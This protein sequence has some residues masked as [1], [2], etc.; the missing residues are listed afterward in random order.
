M[1]DEFAGVVQHHVVAFPAELIEP[2]QRAGALSSDLTGQRLGASRLGAV[3][4]YMHGGHLRP[5]S[6]A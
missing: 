3:F 4:G 2:A 1:A 6:H 5:L